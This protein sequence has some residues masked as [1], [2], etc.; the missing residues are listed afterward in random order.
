MVQVH[1]ARINDLSATKASI[2]LTN[3][4]NHSPA[5]SGTVTETTD[6]PQAIASIDKAADTQLKA[7]ISEREEM[8]NGKVSTSTQV[9]YNIQFLSTFL[10]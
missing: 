7:T 10:D 2:D 5:E 3:L 1:K 9:L 6:K 4:A 8:P